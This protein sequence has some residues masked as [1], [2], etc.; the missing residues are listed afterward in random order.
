M[1]GRDPCRSAATPGY[2]ARHARHGRTAFG[3]RIEISQ[4]AE[5]GR[6]SQL[7]ARV[8][9]T[10]DRVETVEVGGGVVVVADGTFRLP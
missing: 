3:D 1:L 10:A 8:P 4:G 5:I 2:G 9:G 7:F 6:P